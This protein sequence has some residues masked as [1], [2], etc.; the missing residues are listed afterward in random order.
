MA[1]EHGRE[2]VGIGQLE[3]MQADIELLWQTLE[4]NKETI[5]PLERKPR[6]GE[7]PASTE[8]CS[9]GT[10]CTSCSSNGC[11]MTVYH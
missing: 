4:F 11:V 9:T 1:E 6:P 5:R 7:R 10:V 3:A 2:A 8:G